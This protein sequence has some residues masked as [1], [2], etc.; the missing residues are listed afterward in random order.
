MNGPGRASGSPRPA[1]PTRSLD[2]QAD[3]L[4]RSEA[5]YRTIF[6]MASDAMFVHDAETGAIVDA[7]RQACRLV[8]CSQAELTASGL[9][10][11]ASGGEYDEEQALALIRKAAAGEPQQFEWRVQN[12]PGRHRWV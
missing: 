11:I 4:R 3:A 9:L 6:E 1:E 8:G 5:R 10:R 7:N 12:P 2:P